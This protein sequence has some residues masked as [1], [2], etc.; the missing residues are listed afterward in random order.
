MNKFLT[1]ITR[2]SLAMVLVIV[3]VTGILTITPKYANWQA[4]E[5]QRSEMLRR[6]ESKNQEIQV[7]KESQQR[8]KTDPEF[9]EFI[10]RQNRLVRPGELLF[11]FDAEQR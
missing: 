5:K 11:I 10:A 9:V 6:I 2:L 3:L 4:L 1:L 7:L 8:F